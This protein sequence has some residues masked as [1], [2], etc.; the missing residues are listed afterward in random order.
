MKSRKLVHK[1]PFASRNR[2]TG[3][4]NKYMDTKWEEQGRTGW[5]IGIDMYTLLILCVK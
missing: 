1:N 4:E 2:D 3:I 5:E